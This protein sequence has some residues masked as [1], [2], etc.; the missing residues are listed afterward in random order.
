M[1]TTYEGSTTNECFVIRTMPYKLK[2]DSVYFFE[3][4]F[5]VRYTTSLFQLLFTVP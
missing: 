2:K 3:E 5:Q 1:E 4:T